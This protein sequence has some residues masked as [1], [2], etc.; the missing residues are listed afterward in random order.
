MCKITVIP[1]NPSNRNKPLMIFKSSDLL[2]NIPS[3]TTELIAIPVQTTSI[4]LRA[5]IS[6]SGSVILSIH[7]TPHA[8][9][10]AIAVFVNEF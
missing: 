5:K 10:N 7:A 8:V 9:K 2:S 6:D 3:S 1:E 4:T